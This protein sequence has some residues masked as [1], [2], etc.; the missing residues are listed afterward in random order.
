NGYVAGERLTIVRPENIFFDEVAVTFGYIGNLNQPA[1]FRRVSGLEHS[2]YH[3]FLLE[4]HAG[5]RILMSADYTVDSGT[6]TLRQAFTL[7]TLGL[8]IADIAHFEQSEDIGRRK[9][10]GF[11]AY[12]EKKIDRRISLGA[13]YAQLDRHGLFS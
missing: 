10:Y 1:V 13:G 8:R 11:S 12:G 4:K 3:Q 6:H 9:R 5:N 2:N 7:N